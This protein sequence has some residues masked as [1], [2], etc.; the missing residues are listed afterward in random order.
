LFIQENKQINRPFPFLAPVGKDVKSPNKLFLAYMQEF[1]FVEAE[2]TIF[3]ASLGDRLLYPASFPVK[4]NGRK[5]LFSR[6]ASQL[7]IGEINPSATFPHVFRPVVG[8][9][10]SGEHHF[11]L[12]QDKRIVN[13]WVENGEDKAELTFDD[14]FPNLCSL[15]KDET[16]K[17]HWQFR[18][19]GVSL[20]G[21]EY[22]LNRKG[23]RMFVE[24]NVLQ[25]WHPG[26][27]P[28]GFKLFVTVFRSF[29]TWPTSYKWVGCVHLPDL[30]M[31][32]GWLRK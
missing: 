10:A 2:G 30:S 15:R 14:G 22:T 8:A 24:L 13:Y 3:R 11:I 21:G 23:D 27:L 16:V 1:D 9:V 32:G 31:S 19:S 7:T 18:L 6:Y 17:G 5:V 26:G 20:T 29:K 25:K 28:F 12:N 4:R